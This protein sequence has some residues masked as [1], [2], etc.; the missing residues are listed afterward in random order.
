ME[1]IDVFWDDNIA[2]LM[3]WDMKDGWT[4]KD[5]QDAHKRSVELGAKID[6]EFDLIVNANRT[7][8]P[9]FA[10][11]RFRKTFETVAPNMRFFV[12]ANAPPIRF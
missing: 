4:F 10:V 8:P 3:F 12:N 7:N 1:K 6:G 2:H 11:S 9:D 5:F